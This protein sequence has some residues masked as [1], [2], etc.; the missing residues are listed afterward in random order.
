MTCLVIVKTPTKPSIFVAGYNGC[1]TCDCVINAV[2]KPSIRG[3]CACR[4][5]Y[6][7][8][9][10]KATE[11]TY[12]DQILGDRKERGEKSLSPGV[13]QLDVVVFV[14]VGDDVVIVPADVGVGSSRQPHHP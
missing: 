11:P 14:L 9:R 1:R 7:I 2:A 12:I 3:T 6:W 4:S 13:W 10:V 5:R 8:I